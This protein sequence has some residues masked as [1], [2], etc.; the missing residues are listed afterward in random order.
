V[1]SR[2]RRSPLEGA[3]GGGIALPG[4]THGDAA[5][6]TDSTRPTGACVNSVASM[7]T[8]TPRSA[9][10]A[11]AP[12]P[13]RVLPP[14]HR[15]GYLDE[16]TTGSPWHFD[17]KAMPKQPH[18]GWFGKGER[19]DGTAAAAD[20]RALGS[21]LADAYG[22]YDQYQER[23][24][25]VPALLEQHAKRVEGL[26]APT[27][28]EAFVPAIADLRAALPD[29]HFIPYVDGAW[30]Q[31]DKDPRLK[32]Q[33]FR[34][35]SAR[36]DAAA[37]VPGALKNTAA[38]VP[39]ADSGATQARVGS[40]AVQGTEAAAALR[41]LGFTP[42]S[43]STPD[44]DLLPVPEEGAYSYT[45]HG[46]VGVI[47]VWSF[48]AD[49]KAATDLQQLIKDAPLHRQKSK[50]IIDMRGNGGGN[51]GYM[52]EWI[53]QML[54]TKSTMPNPYKEGIGYPSGK[55]AALSAW[56]WSVFAEKY[57]GDDPLQKDLIEYGR[58]MKSLWPLSDKTPLPPDGG[59]GYVDH[60][61]AKTDWKG[62]IAVLVDRRNGS[63][64]ESAAI[65]LRDSLGAKV[66]GERTGGYL[67][68]M[69][70]QT[71]Q[72]PKTGFTVLVPS[73]RAS[74]K[75][76]RI[77]ESAGIPVDAALQKPGAPVE[78]VAQA[79]F[80]TANLSKAA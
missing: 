40:I 27:A 52:R 30:Q 38:V 60:G 19:V 18:A 4:Q 24:V 35:N 33:E 56:N 64:G 70:V 8:V 28:L 7:P 48:G 79:L 63:S 42:V 10:P 21:L 2:Q 43:K 62:D 71:Y 78:A 58:S 44:A 1:A 61:S 59:G 74:W 9:S 13:P 77:A 54:S 14:E 31:L 22:R 47:R 39:V 25:D 5:R 68:G 76:S 3:S 20:L 73:I 53:K 51:D 49:G 55:Q 29:N 26:K 57:M 67:E 46:D 17:P 50:L 69:N 16:K 32:V 72:L 37:A 6:N 15:F 11:A 66:V 41:K 36:L 12:A 23:R 75:D 45:E 65:W 80:G 34:G